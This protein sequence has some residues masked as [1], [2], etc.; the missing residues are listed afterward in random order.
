MLKNNIPQEQAEHIVNTVM[1]NNIF[2]DVHNTDSGL[3]RSDQMRQNFY[4]NN[5]ALVAPVSVS[6]W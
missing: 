3:P 2:N 6:P 1:W 4:R 5:F